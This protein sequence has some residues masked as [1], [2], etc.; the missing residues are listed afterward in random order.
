MARYPDFMTTKECPKC[1]GD[2][3]K[4]T[5]ISGNN[6]DFLQRECISCGYKFREMTLDA[7]KETEDGKTQGGNRIGTK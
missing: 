4:S 1:G 2:K 3:F 5:F 7:P 6:S